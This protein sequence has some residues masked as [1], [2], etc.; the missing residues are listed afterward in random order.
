VRSA[1]A[2]DTALDDTTVMAEGTLGEGGTQ[3][4]LAGSQPVT[5]VLL[6]ITKLGGGG[7]ENITQINEVQFLRAGA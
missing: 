7:S 2:A 4:S 3:I 6:W 5:H 1:Q